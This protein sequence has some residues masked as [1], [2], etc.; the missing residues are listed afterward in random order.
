MATRTLLARAHLAIA[1]LFVGCVA[2]QT[3]LIGLVLFDEGDIAL[4]RTFGIVIFLLAILVPVSAG[5]ARLPTSQVQ[6]SAALLGV[7]FIQMFLAS[8]K[9]SGPSPIAALHPVGALV[10]F[11]LGVLVARR[12]WILVRSPA[13][14]RSGATEDRPTVVSEAE[15]GPSP[16]RGD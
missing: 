16:V 11:A 9:W 7:T 12:A 1:C 6:L 14:A 2:I 4:H 15:T 8:L 13:I 3:F 10:V 5:L